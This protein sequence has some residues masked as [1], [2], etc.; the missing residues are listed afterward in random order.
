MNDEDI[1]GRADNDDGEFED[2][3]DEDEGV[4]EGE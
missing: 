4:E 2:V 1:A 3:E